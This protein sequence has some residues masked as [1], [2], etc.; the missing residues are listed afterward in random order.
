MESNCAESC[1]CSNKFNV[2]FIVIILADNLINNYYSKDSLT[3][4]HKILR[5]YQSTYRSAITK[6]YS[7]ILPAHP[8]QIIN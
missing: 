1:Q 2:F 8:T 7:Q 6:I 4:S 3:N 5:C